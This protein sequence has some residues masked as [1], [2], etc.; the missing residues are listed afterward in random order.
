[1][2]NQLKF[3]FKKESA[4]FF[5][6]FKFWGIVIAVFGF[7]IANPVMYKL[8]G[9]LLAEL[10]K[11][12][13]E[14]QAAVQPSPEDAGGIFGGMDFS[15]MVGMYNDATVMFAT[16]LTS[17]AEFSLLAAMLIMMSAAGGEQK[18]RA[19]IVPLCS[20]LQTKNYL[21]PKFV[22]YPLS[23]FALTFLG[24]LLSGGLCNSVFEN[25]KVSGG[26]I[27]LGAL[28]IAVYFSF[29]VTVYL[30]LGLCTSRPGIMVAAVFIS[31]TILQTFLD[32][33]GLT[34]FQPFTLMTLV[35]GTMFA[36]G[37]SLSDNLP[38]ILTAVALSIVI[39]VLMY[40]LAVLVLNAKKID[41]TA[42]DKP[43][44]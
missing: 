41:N 6:T 8:S 38:S 19:M 24:G 22:I 42:E 40:F 30:S 34:D 43:E 37:F 11:G 39:E 15:E 32:S 12:G 16:C 44:F 23:T 7:A 3:S 2:S 26:Y 33:A 17:F 9:V 35:S 5:R 20:G 27:A 28:F 1:M 25:R 4:H 21:I 14:I 18:K 13:T 10:N 29:I 36:P 31:R